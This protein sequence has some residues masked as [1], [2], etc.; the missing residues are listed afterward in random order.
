VVAL[1]A[2]AGVPWAIY[3]AMSQV[4]FWERRTKPLLWVTPS[5]AVVNLILVVILLPPFGL[6]GAAAATCLAMIAQAGL[7][8]RAA[9]SM[10]DVPWPWREIA[11]NALLALALV[12]VS[13]VL[14]ESD[15]A[16]PVRALLI[17]A[18]AAGAAQTVRREFA[19]TP[20]SQPS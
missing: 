7:A 11:L 5:A 20:A 10:A 4:M 18:I 9:R 19:V 6:E 13:V 3:L 16:I 2:L 1:V 14:G 15:L 17:L 12:A 8:A